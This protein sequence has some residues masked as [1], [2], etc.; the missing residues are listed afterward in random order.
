MNHREFM[1][2]MRHRLPNAPAYKVETRAYKNASGV[3][4]MIHL[5]KS[6]WDYVDWADPNT[7]IDFA[8]WIIH[9]DQNQTEGYT[10]S[11]QLWYWLWTDHCNRFRNGDPTPNPYPP[12]GY[13]GWAG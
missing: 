7:D 13:E 10:L 1:H 12:M 4:E 3:D 5:P 9:C 6:W 11:H 8:A 2:D